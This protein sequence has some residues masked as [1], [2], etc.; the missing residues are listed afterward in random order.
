MKATEDQVVEDFKRKLN[1]AVEW[2]KEVGYKESDVE[3]FIKEVR[4][5][6][7]KKMVIRN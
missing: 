6:K 1:E 7:A 3:V 2:A 4:K 5:K